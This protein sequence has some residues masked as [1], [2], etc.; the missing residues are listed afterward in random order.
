MIL[1][2]NLLSRFKCQ[3]SALFSSMYAT[4]IHREAVVTLKIHDSFGTPRRGPFVDPSP[5]LFG[6]RP[7]FWEPLGFI[8]EPTVVLSCSDKYFLLLVQSRGN[9]HLYLRFRK[10]TFL[11][12]EWVKYKQVC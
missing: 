11:Q 9:N 1:S 6:F 3:Q 7:I 4:D 2:S 10:H 8:N 12:T 5:P